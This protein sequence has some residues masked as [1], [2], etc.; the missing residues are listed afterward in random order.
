VIFKKDTTRLTTYSYTLQQGHWNMPTWM[1][2][3][4]SAPVIKN[5]IHLPQHH[6]V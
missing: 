3:T 2:L 4:T 5:I 6:S 1:D